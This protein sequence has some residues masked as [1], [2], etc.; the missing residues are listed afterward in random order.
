MFLA[1]LEWEGWKIDILYELNVEVQM[2]IHFV[3]V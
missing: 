1:F 3:R 2:F